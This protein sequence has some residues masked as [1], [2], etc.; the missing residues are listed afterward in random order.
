MRTCILGIPVILQKFPPA[1]FFFPGL[2]D[3][4]RLTAGSAAPR[5]AE[6]VKSH[7]CPAMSAGH[8]HDPGGVFHQ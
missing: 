8:A 4:G 2:A 6:D 5:L 7:G 3:P 1:N